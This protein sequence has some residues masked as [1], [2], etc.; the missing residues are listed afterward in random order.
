MMRR[1]WKCT[2][3]LFSAIVLSLSL[4]SCGESPPPASQAK[5]TRDEDAALL[6]DIGRAGPELE[7]RLLQSLKVED[8]LIFV[9]DPNPV[10]AR[11]A[12][13]VLPASSPWVIS[14]GISGISVTFG[15]AIS[16][17]GSS[18]SNDVELFLA[19]TIIEP[20]DCGVLGSRL[21]KRL[22]AVLQEPPR[23]P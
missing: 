4:N 22:K 15:S 21:G 18:V 6:K 20:D 8:G 16:G 17:D 10:L 23:S 2:R 7:R 3:Q 13:F 5:Q 12:S 11:V 19:R 1:D 14:C 9:R